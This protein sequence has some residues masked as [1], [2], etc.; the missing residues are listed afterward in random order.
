M[1]SHNPND[2][3]EGEDYYL[4]P[5]GYKVFTEKYHLQRGYCCK[6]GCRHCPYGYD[7]KT[8]EFKK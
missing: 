3:V 1:Y 5:E 2:L 7:K 8:G 4:T 6:S